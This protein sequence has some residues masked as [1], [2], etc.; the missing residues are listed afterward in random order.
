MSPANDLPLDR[1]Q[2]ETCCQQAAAGDPDA[3]TRLLCAYHGRLLGFARRKV[4]V[5]WNG[6]IDPEDLLQETYIDIVAALGQ[7]TCG[8]EDSFYHWATRIIDHRFVDQVRHWRRQKRAAAR[9]VQPS[10]EAGSGLQSLLERCLPDLGTPSVALRR[11]D[12]TAALMSG[13]ACLPEDY[14]V[15]VQRLH[16]KQESL[17]TVAADLGR[18]EDA[19]RRLAGRALER[20]AEHLGRASRYLSSHG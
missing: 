1:A 14:R 10:A 4:G 11:V 7:F 6:K 19:I 8:D 17:A 9:E 20:L 12:A 2:L 3:L 5:D 15:V 13:I 18:T 16:L